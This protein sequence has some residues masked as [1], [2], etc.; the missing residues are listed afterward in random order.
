MAEFARNPDGTLTQLASPDDCIQEQSVGSTDCG[1]ETGRGFGGAGIAISPG[2]DSVYVTGISDVAEFARTPV[3][4]TVMV[5]HHGAGHGL[6]WN[7]RDL[8]PFDLL[9]HLHGGNAGDPAPAAS[10]GSA[11]TGWSG[12]GCSGTGPCQIRLTADTTV[13][14]GSP[15]VPGAACHRVAV[16]HQQ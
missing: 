14:A 13:A 1:N 8:L 15:A 4:H 11:F 9:A 10:P 6:G 16:G 5:S 7:R 3:L 2:G 12:G